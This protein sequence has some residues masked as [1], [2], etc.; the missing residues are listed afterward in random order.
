MEETRQRGKEIV[1][2]YVPSHRGIKG[3]EEA[4][5][6]AKA[7]HQLQYVTIPDT[8][9][10]EGKQLIDMKLREVW[11]DNWHQEVGRGNV[12]THLAYIR[13]GVE[14]W[15]RSSIPKNR[16]LEIMMA[17][18]RIGYCGL[19]YNMNR[20]GMVWSSLCECEE[21]ET[22]EHCL[23]T[24][25]EH[26]GQRGELASKLNMIGVQLTM[27]NVLRGGEYGANKQNL[28]VSYLWESISILLIKRAMSVVVVVAV[29]IG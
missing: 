5:K 22:L 25:T 7:A 1:F 28:I 21:M 27:K 17:R 20:F 19:R 8:T 9:V 4:D 23:I 10:K 13:A 24:C 18:L 16:R 14:R 26:E 3:N 15:E 11:G 2:F 6:A 29:V 12:G